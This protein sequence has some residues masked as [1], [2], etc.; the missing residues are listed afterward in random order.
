[1][2]DLWRDDPHPAV[3]QV[4]RRLTDLGAT[5]L[6]RVHMDVHRALHLPNLTADAVRDWYRAPVLAKS[7]T[8]EQR[9]SGSRALMIFEELRHA[10]LGAQHARQLAEAV[11]ENWFAHGLVEDTARKEAMKGYLIGQI[12]A[13][14]EVPPRPPAA[15]L[16]DPGRGGAITWAGEHAAEHLT[17]L[18]E[19]TRRAIAGHVMDAVIGQESAGALAVRLGSAFGTLNRDWRRVAITELAFARAS[20]Y[21]LE[22]PVGTRVRWFAAQD[23]CGH[24]AGLDGQEFEVTHA[25]G[26]W[27]AQ[28]WPGKT[29]VG[30]AFARKRRDGTPRADSELAAP[31]I[32]L[33]PNC[34]C[35]WVRAE[36]RVPGVSAAMEAYLAQLALT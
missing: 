15:L 9:R 21:L 2:E 17:R 33:H 20:G 31:C 29:N 25:P 35:R 24:C 14:G 13:A 5:V 12:E 22:L 8:D 10:P 11:T 28:V 16:G 4:E 19:N 18:R 36:R 32:P 34:R 3:A 30:R 23:A 27:S 1:M 7:V 6:Y 26:D